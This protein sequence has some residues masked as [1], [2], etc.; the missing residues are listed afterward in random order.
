MRKAI[1]LTNL[2]VL[3]LLLALCVPAHAA[4]SQNWNDFLLDE[5]YA[6]DAETASHVL[7]LGQTEEVL[8]VALTLEGLY[9]DGDDF[10]LGWRME[11]LR[12]E[13]PAL[14]LATDVFIDGTPHFAFAD[15]PLSTW[16][17]EM[18]GLFVA[19]DPINNLM[20]GY[21]AYMED[22]D[23]SGEVE[24]SA[25]FTVKRPTK[26][27]AVVDP[28][29][30]VAY[31]DEGTETDRQ[32]MMEAMRTYGVTI[33]EPGDED[34][35]A[36]KEKGYLVLNRYGEHYPDD[37]SEGVSA[38]TGLDLPDSET[39]EVVMSFHVNLDELR[40]GLR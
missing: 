32:A 12:P 19:G 29:I 15:H 22:F 9:Y 10:L 28:E 38:I 26:P 20:K 14:V 11:N 17:P 13:E 34:V 35:D 39:Q 6:A 27:I 30:H 2:F 3:L 33:A 40:E 5:R 18:F 25:Y 37:P 16:L 21:H 36:W 1:A 8:D 31:D 7:V 4:P 24:V 23:W